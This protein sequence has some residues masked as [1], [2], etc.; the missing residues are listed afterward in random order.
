VDPG[1]IL[2]TTFLEN[3]LIARKDFQFSLAESFEIS[4]K[5]I[6]HNNQQKG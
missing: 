4:F 6:I 3:F 1:W 5:K 2:G